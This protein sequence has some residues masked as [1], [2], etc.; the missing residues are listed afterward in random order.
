MSIFCVL[1]VPVVIKLQLH[2]KNFWHEKCSSHCFKSIHLQQY[3]H[4]TPSHLVLDLP[5]PGNSPSPAVPGPSVDESLAP[6]QC[7]H[8][9]RYNILIVSISLK[10]IVHYKPIQLLESQN[11]SNN[12][13]K[14]HV[15][16][17]L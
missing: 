8:S 13:Y 3:L 17:N 4:V 6:L 15:H 7:F 5:G 11:N 9:V 10:I 1:L 12:L 14:V 2:Y 16:S